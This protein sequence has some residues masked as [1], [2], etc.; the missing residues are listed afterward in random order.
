VEAAASPGTGNG[1]S[2]FFI[3]PL[4]I[5]AAAFA[6]IVFI[7]Y[8][9]RKTGQVLAGQT[10]STGGETATTV[11]GMV[12]ATLQHESPVAGEREQMV[13]EPEITQTARIYLFGNFEVISS[14]GENITRL[15]RPCL[16]NC[17]CWCA[18]IPSGTKKAF[19]PKN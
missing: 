1:F 4:L 8:K 9:K 16:K 10:G 6:G 11:P 15:L 3:A 18:Y 14:T 5:I 19:R 13:T 7:R 17:S 12:P 2:Y